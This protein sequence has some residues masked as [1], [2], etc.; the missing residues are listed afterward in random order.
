MTPERVWRAIRQGAEKSDRAEAGTNAYGGAN[1][2]S[3]AGK[4]GEQL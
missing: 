1:L 3:T 2:S 4:E